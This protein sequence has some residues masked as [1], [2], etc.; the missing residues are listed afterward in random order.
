MTE[1]PSH[2][3]Q[4]GR[5]RGASLRQP[6]LVVISAPSGAGKT[7]LVR[8]LLAGDD[9]VAVS[10]S[11]TTRPP[12]PTDVDGRDYHFVSPATFAA[13]RDAGEFLEHAT[14]FGHAYG[15]SRQA[16][17]DQV[18]CGHDVILEIDWQG[19]AQVREAWPD[20]VTVFIL[21]PSRQALLARIE[22]RGQDQPAVIARRMEEAAIELAQHADFDHL[23]VN[24]DFEQ[25]TQELA[26]IVTGCRN[27]SPPPRAQ[28][29]ELLA[30]LLGER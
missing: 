18:A 8:A 19:A 28:H 25:A 2:T 15:T 21:P 10:V 13:M 23:V 9:R 17:L 26:T 3:P 14:V 27:D 20:A 4:C 29:T 5:A 7:S 1:V 6:L 11:H 22:G 12:R 16:V 24:D 30:R